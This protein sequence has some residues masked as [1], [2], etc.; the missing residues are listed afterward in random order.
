[1]EEALE[2]NHNVIPEAEFGFYYKLTPKLQTMLVQNLFSE[3]L[4]QFKHFFDGCS[5]HFINEMVTQMYSQTFV[6]F[7]DI[8]RYKKDFHEVFFIV[9]GQVSLRLPKG[10]KNS[11][12][13][14]PQYSVFG[15]FN[16]L[17]N[18][19]ASY[20]YTAVVNGQNESIN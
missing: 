11:F 1:M 14:L 7:T 19:K 18:Q 13:V 9:K 17:F 2:F 10:K 8:V 4:L 20:Y 16:C 6:E 3:F 12:L 15:E 5:H